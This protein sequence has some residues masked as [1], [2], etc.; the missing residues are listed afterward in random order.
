MRR[1]FFPHG[2]AHLTACGKQTLA[3][4]RYKALHTSGMQRGGHGKAT[5]QWLP[6]GAFLN[7]PACN[8]G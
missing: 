8:V 2:F 1:S 3:L 4:V 7:N 5:S 6:E